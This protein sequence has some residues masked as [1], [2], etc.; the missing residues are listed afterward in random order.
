MPSTPREKSPKVLFLGLEDVPT[1][2][3]VSCGWQLVILDDVEEFEGFDGKIDVVVFTDRADDL[4][5]IM[6]EVRERGAIGIVVVET[7]AQDAFQILDAIG[8]HS[9]VTRPVDAGQLTRVVAQE[10]R[11]RAGKPHRREFDRS[12][13]RFVGHS[14]LVRR[15]CEQVAY[16]A[17]STA[18]V[19]VSGE[20]GTGKEL[21]AKAIHRLSPRRTEP[22][23]VV[24][25][26]AIPSELIESE[27]FGHE[28]GAFTS[29]ESQR[30][31]CFEVADGGTLFL[32]EIGELQSM[33]QVKILRALQ[34]GQFSRVGG[35]GH[36]DVDVRI[37]AATNR[38]LEAD[39]ESGAFRED[40]YY[41]LNV[42]SLKL[43]PLRERVSDVRVLWEHFVSA[44]ATV[45]GSEPP[46]TNA[47]VLRLLE[48]HDWPGNIRELENVARRVVAMRPSREITPAS[49]P[50]QVRA[51]PPPDRVR[52]PG[53]TLEE[54]ERYA[55]LKTYDT[56]GSVRRTAEILDVSERK[57]FYRLK[58]YREED[59]EAIEDDRAM[60]ALVEDDVDFRNALRE[61]LSRSYRVV[62]FESVEELLAALSH[63]RP[64]VIVSDVRLPNADGLSILDELSDERREIPVILMSAFADDKTRAL[65][66]EKGAVAFLEKPV[67]TI[68]LGRVLERATRERSSTPAGM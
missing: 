10:V 33:V 14:E 58:Q 45:E 34:H 18:P 59:S 7:K 65:A 42:L 46:T 68:L 35:T 25:C 3:S 27:L 61:L 26:G 53:M 60:L 39:V 24:N 44:A 66:R 37:I 55:I 21:V 2:G 16:V 5:R 11:F 9:F 28:K 43:P 54:L 49:L 20:S 56:T 22:L 13:P 50:R 8:A 31:G 47:D 19:L 64:A 52:I 29:A 32:D 41:R 38:N 40:L 62:E 30:L 17:P 63:D 1:L 12:V 6:D 23:V 57:I 48:R 67:D 4:E 15:I 36:I 51:N